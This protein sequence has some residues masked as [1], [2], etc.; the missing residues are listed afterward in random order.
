[1]RYADHIRAVNS[2]CT[3]ALRHV[4]EFLATMRQGTTVLRY[5]FNTVQHIGAARGN[6]R[7]HA[8]QVLE[9]TVVLC[10]ERHF[11]K[12]NSVICLKANILA[13]P[14]YLA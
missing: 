8:P 2:V 6:Q 4:E 9:H 10:F 3:V 1:M 14:K 5:F 13:S 11:S 7:G 12:Q